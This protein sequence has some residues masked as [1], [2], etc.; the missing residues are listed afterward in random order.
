[1]GL[2]RMVL[3]ARTK[4]GGGATP[5]QVAEELRHAGT[6]VP[7]DDIRKVWDEGHQDDQGTG[8]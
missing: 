2:P 3:E 1:M 6:A 4:L 8:A 7:L 5:E